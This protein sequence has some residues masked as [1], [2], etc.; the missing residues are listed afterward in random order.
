MVTSEQPDA[1][2]GVDTLLDRLEAAIG[3][4]AAG[5]APVEELVADYEEAVRLL[6]EAETRLQ[7]LAGQAR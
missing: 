6:A 1:S 7:S 5:Q 3:R 4:L 2:A